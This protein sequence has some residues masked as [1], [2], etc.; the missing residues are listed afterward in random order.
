MKKLIPMAGIVVGLASTTGIAAAHVRVFAQDG[1]QVA[2]ACGYE[3]FVVRVPV[4][5]PIDTVGVNLVIPPAI[6]VFATQPKAGWHAELKMDRGRVSEIDWSG[7]ALHP[8]EFDEFA[9]LAATPRTPMTVDW[10]ADQIYDDRS[11]VH[12]TGA[13]GSDTPHSQT[14]IERNDAVCRAHAASGGRKK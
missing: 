7:G 2:K 10:N 3:K 5:K 11:I 8:H 12:W 14:T 9:F 13:P 1:S 4:E 6:T